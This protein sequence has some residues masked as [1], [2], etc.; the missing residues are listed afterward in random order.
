MKN[1]GR[2][3]V[4]DMLRNVHPFLKKAYRPLELKETKKE[5]VFKELFGE[6]EPV[7]LYKLRA[8]Y[9]YQK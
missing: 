5:E 3:H 2:Q 1:L 9:E 4:K 6:N 7:E 8:I